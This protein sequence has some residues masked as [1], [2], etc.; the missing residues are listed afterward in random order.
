MLDD[1]KRDEEMIKLF[2]LLKEQH[3]FC[4]PQD[5]LSQT[6]HEVLQEEDY[7]KDLLTEEELDFIQ[8]AAGRPEH[9]MPKRD[10]DR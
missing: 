8:A 6:I 7:D 9:I 2:K 5:Q 10:E 4:D 3:E 1:L